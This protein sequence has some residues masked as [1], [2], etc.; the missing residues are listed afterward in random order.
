MNKTLIICDNLDIALLYQVNLQVYI[1]SGAK[2]INSFDNAEKELKISK[3]LFDFIIFFYKLGEKSTSKLIEAS[4]APNTSIVV[5][6]NREND[7]EELHIADAHIIQ[8]IFDLKSILRIGAKTFGITAQMMAN[9]PLNSHYQL[10]NRLLPLLDNPPCEIYSKKGDE[11]ISVSKEQIKDK[12]FFI[13]SKERLKLINYLTINY[14]EKYIELMSSKEALKISENVVENLAHQ[15]TKDEAQAQEVL[16]VA[17][18]AIKVINSIIRKEKPFLKLFKLLIKNQTNYL[19]VHSVL[20]QYTTKHIL[21]NM[22]WGNDE[23]IHKMGIANILHDIYLTPLYIKHPEFISETQFLETAVF[24]D[25][26]REVV[27]SHAYM[28]ATKIKQWNQMPVDLDSILMQHHG[29]KFGR[30]FPAQPDTNIIPLARVFIISEAFVEQ[31]LLHNK[32]K[33]LFKYNI[34]FEILKKKYKSKQFHQIIDVLTSIE[35]EKD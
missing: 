25:K 6:D 12:H 14:M 9:K 26:D 4:K 19:Y 33:P 15:L 2:I 29:A 21:E 27:E 20:L 30:G 11:Y 24:N 28:V 1:D 34:I 16:D 3:G 32:T 8:N 22:S 7:S 23:Q 18:K 10:P 17:S 31:F 35:I 13:E 5:V